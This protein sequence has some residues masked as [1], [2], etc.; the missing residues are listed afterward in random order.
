MTK[1]LENKT[2]FITGGNIGI[3]KAA[4]KSLAKAGAKIAIA[5]RSEDSGEATVKEIKDT[6]G[7]AL[8]IK[9]DVSRSEDVEAAIA[10]TVEHF[11]ELN[12]AF[13]NAGIIREI[14][15]IE[16]DEA[17]WDKTIDVNLKG[18]WLSMK[19]QIPQ[20]IKSGGGAIVNTSSILGVVAAPMRSA[21]IASKWGLIGLT[22][23]AALEYA[24]HNI[25]VNAVAP[26]GV[27]TP[28]YDEYY[29]NKPE[30]KAAFD[31]THPLGR[32]AQ[33]MEIAEAVTWLLS[34]A[35]SFVTGQ[36]LPVDGGYTAQ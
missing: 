18:V 7:E 16:Q 10:K 26:G 3:G 22:K 15:L 17:S 27:A 30:E 19:Y 35:A 25:R 29:H 2:A 28:M 31:A 34:D 12:I 36:V 5:A 33:P 20:M 13:N 9:T 1:L 4:A 14:A 24:S 8:F 23:A 21:Y 32:V 11:G 6:G